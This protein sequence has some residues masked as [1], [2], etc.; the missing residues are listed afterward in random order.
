[1]NKDMHKDITVVWI[2]NIGAEKI[3]HKEN[4]Q[5]NDKISNIITNRIEELNLFIAKS[6]DIVILRNMPNK[7]YLDYLSKAGFAI[8]RILVVNNISEEKTITELLLNDNRSLEKLKEIALK[9]TAILVPYAVTELEEKVAK[10]CNIN[11]WGPTSSIGALINDKIKVR[12]LAKK[13]ELNYTDGEVCRN[14]QDIRLVANC[15]FVKGFEKLILKSPCNA[16]GQGIFVSNKLKEIERYF[17]YGKSKGINEWI[18]EGWY[19]D[20]LSLNCQI[21]INGQGSVKVFSIKEQM[22]DGVVYK[23]SLIS[24]QIYENN[25]ELIKIGETIGRYL[26][27]KYKY[28]GL[29]G[30]DVIKTDYKEYRL[31]E[32]NARFTLSSY[33]VYLEKIYEGRYLCFRYIDLF[34]DKEIIFENLLFILHENYLL[35]DKKKNKGI[36]PLVAGTLPKEISRSRE[37]LLGRLFVLVIGDNSADIKRLLNNMLKIIKEIL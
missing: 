11:I 27:G 36:I 31:M 22:M 4:I 9:E 17:Q 29:L 35:Y 1:M 5:S 20:S 21:H 8:P 33:L 19:E 28:I 18:L 34:S 14:I 3:W 15:L 6:N 37:I 16:S 13:L 12:S 25:K 30:V 32:I 24:K 23:G 26:Y 7:S 2:F 10:R